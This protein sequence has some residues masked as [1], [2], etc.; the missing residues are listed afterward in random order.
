MLP[1]DLKIIV[2]VLAAS[3]SKNVSFVQFN[4]KLINIMANS[5]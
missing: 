3:K 2:F 5:Q 1:R 4:C